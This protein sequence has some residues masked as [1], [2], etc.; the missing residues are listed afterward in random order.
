MTINLN[1]KNLKQGVMGLVLALVEIIRDALRLQAIRRIESGRLT[2]EETE[3]LGSAL[4]DL[5]EA[6]E[7]IKEEQGVTQAVQNVR[8]G[9]DNLAND[10]LNKI[11]NP[12]VL[13]EQSSLGCQRQKAS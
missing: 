8:D 7:K 11:I 4:A 2:D 10:M 5:D 3:R 1:E 13:R 9:L 6:I 12:E